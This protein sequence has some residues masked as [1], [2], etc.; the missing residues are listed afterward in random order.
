MVLPEEGD[1]YVSLRRGEQMRVV[2]TAKG[3][4]Y[5][6]SSVYKVM[7]Y[8]TQM[9]ISVMDTR[10]Y[11]ILNRYVHIH[12]HA[13]IHVHIHTRTHIHVHIHTRVH[14]HHWY[15][16]IQDMHAH[17]YAQS[18]LLVLSFVCTNSGFNGK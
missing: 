2:L 1:R 13:H 14:M 11:H 9:Y 15:T 3:P 10:A 6:P 4:T 16:N 17:T 5:E 8:K 7:L 18:V 12:T